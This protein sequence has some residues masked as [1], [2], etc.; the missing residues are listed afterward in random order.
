[1]ASTTSEHVT[2]KLAAQLGRVAAKAAAHPATGEV[3]WRAERLDSEWSWGFGGQDAPF[4]IASITKLYTN[5]LLLQLVDAGALTLDAVAAD[6][7]PT[8]TMRGLNTHG[9]TDHSASITVRQLLNQTSGL[10]DYFEDRGG[11]LHEALSTDRG[12]TPEEAIERTRTLPAHFAP[13]AARAYYSDTNFTLLG[14]VIESASGLSYR[15]ALNA[16][17]LEPLALSNSYLFDDETIDRYESVAPIFSKGRAVHLPQTLASCGSQGAIVS[18]LSDS[19]RFVRAFFGGE[20]FDA[21]WVPQL[22][23]STHRV[24]GPLSYGLG[25]M[26]YSLPRVFSPLA[27]MPVLTGHS[28]S[29]GSVLYYSQA[30]KLLVAGTVNQIDKR[31][32]S[33]QYLARIAA[34]VAKG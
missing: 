24:F 34:L 30:A 33:H 13:G 11:M 22:T 5:A 20:L 7:L 17:I 10:A 18:T 9:G 3:L 25:V 16:G 32:L 26:Q 12:W 23:A 29:A 28:G 1:M 21:A 15:D 2:D 19:S 4:F 27:P 6:Y 14:M 31:Q 8:G